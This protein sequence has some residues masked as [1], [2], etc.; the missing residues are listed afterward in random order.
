M[1][2]LLEKIV[3]TMT[4]VFTPKDIQVMQ[5]L[6]AIRDIDAMKELTDLNL[7]SFTKQ[8]S[9]IATD[10]RIVMEENFAN[11]KEYM[12]KYHKANQIN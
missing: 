4:Q 7:K 3:D 10:E 8:K 5:N 1:K 6:I 9:R 12:D 2:T 11:L